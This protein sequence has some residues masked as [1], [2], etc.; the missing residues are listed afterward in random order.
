MPWTHRSFWLGPLIIGVILAL[1]SLL[2]SRGR[3]R[4]IYRERLQE[5]RRERLFLAALGF[6]VSVLVECSKSFS[7]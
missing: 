6:F 5:S 3:L 1:L 7:T 2:F 4:A